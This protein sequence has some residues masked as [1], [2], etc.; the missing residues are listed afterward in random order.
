MEANYA[1]IGAR[2]FSGV[3][4]AR[5]RSCIKLSP[6][7]V[8]FVE[9]NGNFSNVRALHEAIRLGKKSELVG[10]VLDVSKA[11]DSVPHEAIATC[12]EA[13][14]VPG[15]LRR[16]ILAMYQDSTTRFKNCGGFEVGLKRGVKQGDPLSALLFN[17]VLDPLLERLEDQRGGLRVG[18]LTI[19][20]LAFADDL[21]LLACDPVAAQLQLDLVV[22][23]LQGWNCLW[24][25]A[26]HSE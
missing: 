21:V 11:F 13:R 18:E 8:G 17:I 26:G 4:D 9:G 23:H 12:F 24:Q 5:L 1:C 7:Q 25:S 6:R 3:K 2:L 10:Q 16:E 20:V 19:S 22:S 14:G 15:P